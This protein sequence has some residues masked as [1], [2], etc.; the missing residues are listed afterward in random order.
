M[1]T[2]ATETF[3]HTDGFA[4]AIS[5]QLGFLQLLPQRYDNI[6]T[7]WHEEEYTGRVRKLWLRGLT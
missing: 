6:K 2:V 7:V 1:N 3:E 4:H 5:G